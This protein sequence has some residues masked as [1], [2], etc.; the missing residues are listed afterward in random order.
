M[1]VLTIAAYVSQHEK[2]FIQM[3]TSNT[4]KA[5]I[6]MAE[7]SKSTTNCLVKI[8]YLDMLCALFEHDAGLRWSLET[9]YWTG[10]YDL[11]MDCQKEDSIIAENV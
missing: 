11:V 8:R 2:N 5:L 7:I 6:K 3:N 10:I 4:F 1:W 9:N